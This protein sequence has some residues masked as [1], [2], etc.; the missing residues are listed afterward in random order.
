MAPL[1]GSIHATISRGLQSYVAE[2]LEVAV[3]T[4]GH[5]LDEVISNLKDAISLHLEG[6]NYESLGLVAAP[7]L[8]VT[9]EL[10]IPHAPA[11]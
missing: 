2:C 5:T 9:Y 8:I 3:V 1:R 10:A 7:R 6:E 11:S 4:Q